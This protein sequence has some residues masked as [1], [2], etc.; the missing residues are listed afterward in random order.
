M[1]SL[2]DE[3]EKKEET[4]GKKGGEI[5]IE[6]LANDVAEKVLK[7]L[8]ETETPRKETKEETKEEPEPEV[9]EKENE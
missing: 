7:K 6:K 3:M 4:D 1:F 9:K 2:F 5:D 8:V